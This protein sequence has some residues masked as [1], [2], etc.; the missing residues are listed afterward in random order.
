[1]KVVLPSTFSADEDYKGAG[2]ILEHLLTASAASAKAKP[3]EHSTT[4]SDPSD[5][6]ML[7][8][9]GYTGKGDVWSWFEQPSNVMRFKRFGAAM[10]GV[11]SV[12]A[13]DA[14]LKGMHSQLH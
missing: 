10:K 12:Q 9:F 14:I 1:M 3:S 7:L 11:S 6:P 4:L 5:T 13:E 2:Y 8:A